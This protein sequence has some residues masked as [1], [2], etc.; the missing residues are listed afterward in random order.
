MFLAG[1]HCRELPNGKNRTNNISC[2]YKTKRQPHVLS[3]WVLQL[4]TDREDT[5]PNSTTLSL[6]GPAYKAVV[7]V[8]GVHSYPNSGIFKDLGNFD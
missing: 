6:K 2:D 8:Q 3:S 4:T 1:T 7:Q 5:S